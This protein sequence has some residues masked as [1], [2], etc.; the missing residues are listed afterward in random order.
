MGAGALLVSSFFT[1]EDETDASRRV[2]VGDG[3]G[4]GAGGIGVGG[5]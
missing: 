1:N 4:V 2:V 5:S 3:G